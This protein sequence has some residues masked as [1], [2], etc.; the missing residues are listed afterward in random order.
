MPTIAREM[1]LL[2]RVQGLID[3]NLNGLTA[4]FG[5]IGGVVIERRSHVRGIWRCMGGAFAWTPAGYNEPV[6]QAPDLEAA[7]TF[8]RDLLSKL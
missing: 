4:G 8:T 5:D 1:E 7:V 2:A 3:G 6:Y